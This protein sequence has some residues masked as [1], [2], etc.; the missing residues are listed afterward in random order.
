MQNFVSRSVSI[1]ALSTAFLATTALAQGPGQRVISRSMMIPSAMSSS[2]FTPMTGRAGLT[3]G[4]PMR[5]CRASQARPVLQLIQV[6]MTKSLPQAGLA[7][8]IPRA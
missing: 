1:V 4:L 7:Q 2:A 8:M 5:S 3:I 6:N